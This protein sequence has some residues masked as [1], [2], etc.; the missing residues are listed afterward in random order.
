M[1]KPDVNLDRL[2]RKHREYDERLEVLAGI[3]FPSEEER[4]EE[5]T[6]KKLKLKVKDEMEAIHK[7]MAEGAAH[8]G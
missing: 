3:R 4:L 7:H 2:A 8:R 5:A 1:E 6:L